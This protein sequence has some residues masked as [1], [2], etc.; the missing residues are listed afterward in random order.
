MRELARAAAGELLWGLAAVAREVR[1]WRARARAI[2]DP[3]L[4]GDALRSLARKRGHTDGAA[5]F[6]IVPRA[7]SVALLRLLVA[8]EVTWDFLDTVNEHGA[9]A[10]QA[11]GRQLHLALV[12]ALDPGRAPLADYYRHHPWRE[13][14]GYLRALVERC[15]ASCLALPAYERLRPRL[16]GEA[17]R[18][19]VLAINHDLDPARRDA[20]LRAW[21]QEQGLAGRPLRWFELTGAASASLTVHALLALAAEPAY[22]EEQIART[23]AA[24]FPWI[25]ATTTMID[26]YVDQLEDAANGDHSY[27]SHY[28]SPA[29]AA[30]RVGE[31]LQRS[32][33]AAGAL[34]DGERHVLL[35]AC[36]AAMY[37][38]KDSARGPQLHETTS[39][40]VAAGGP[41][42]R[43][44]LP[45]LRFW[46]T[47]YAQRGA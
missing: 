18:A 26:S 37:L 34:P 27:V 3:A 5:L 32:L 8:Y 15:R 33:A 19:Q 35:V 21:A 4:R 36:M 42:T 12:D 9:R 44:L 17:W 22:S 2:P 41:L 25:S 40:L 39:R 1:A 47:A 43:L 29:V 31:L 7:R 28:P 45:I 6:W 30:H 14:G 20:D 13:D 11:N 16:L 46:R 24:Y 10:G 38:S 23:H